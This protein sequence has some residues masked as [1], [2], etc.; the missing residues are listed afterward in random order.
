LV[1]NNYNTFEHNV[2][3][4]YN[5]EDTIVFIIFS[6]N[7]TT[8]FIDTFYLEKGMFLQY[9]RHSYADQSGINTP[10][11]RWNCSIAR[12]E[13]VNPGFNILIA[14]NDINTEPFP[15]CHDLGTWTFT[16][17]PIGLEGQTID[18]IQL[19]GDCTTTPSPEPIVDDDVCGDADNDG[20]KDYLDNCPEGY[21]PNQEDTDNDGQG[22]ICDYLGNKALGLNTVNPLTD[23]HIRDSQVYIDNPYKGIIMMGQDSFC[24][25]LVINP[26]GSLINQKVECPE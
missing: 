26:Q 25:R 13:I 15:P 22:D 2:E 1:P 7:Q 24:Y 16:D 17:A 8:N 11:L 9:N 18:S 23:F 14:A 4:I 12:W 21:N 3:K 20:L 19:I 5:L 10:D 6:S